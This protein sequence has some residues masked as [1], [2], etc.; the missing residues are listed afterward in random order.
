V[1]V[2]GAG[3]AGIIFC[4][5]LSRLRPDLKLVLLEYGEASPG[6]NSLDNSI[7]V[8]TP[9]HHH[10]PGES[11]NKGFGG[12]SRTWGGRCVSYDEIDFLDRTILGENCTWDPSIFED[13][14]RYFTIAADY[15]ECGPP[16][17]SFAECFP[18]GKGAI[19]DLFRSVEVTDDTLERWSRPTRF[20]EQHRKELEKRPNLTYLDPIEVHEITTSASGEVAIKGSR[21]DSTESVAIQAATVIIS[22]G[23][24]ETTRLL[25]KNPSLFGGKVPHSLGKFYQ[26]HVSGK[27]A[28]IQFSGDPKKTD[29]GFHLDGGVYVR[30]RFQFTTE[31]LVKH[32]LLNVALWLDN[33]LYGE[34]SH[35]NGTLS[36][37]YLMMK[38]PVLSRK[39]APPSIA[40]S[41]TKGG[42]SPVSAHL[43]NIV[44]NFPH[45]LLQP[46][47]LFAGRYLKAKKLPGVFLYN[48]Q[49]RYA[50]HFHSE[51]VPTEANYMRLGPDGNTLI[52]QY[53]YQ[54]EDVD[55]VIR[56]HD[57]L[58]KNLRSVNAGQLHYWHA[59]D[60][61]PSAILAWSKDGIHQVG[62]TRISKG[63][64]NGVVN[65]DLRLWSCDNV[66]VCSS[67]TF[68]TSGQANPTFLLAAFAAR[69]ADHISKL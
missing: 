24:Q 13:V 12:T 60:E 34:A 51:Q 66:Y 39:L 14:K 56:A 57:L 40:E 30:R 33:P 43:W 54:R 7:D 28:S 47:A 50:L 16:H 58:D 53:G 45:S 23:A 20:G 38:L 15:L 55:S 18:D 63:P 8:L 64:D 1:C 44:R 17:F 5:E 9:K 59:S 35:K 68:P 25:L 48:S 3:L 42:T 36:F 31:A 65:Y 26:G 32:N 11:T 10:P 19:S 41:V 2:V 61:L 27:I 62:T 29:F 6:E 49:N 4:L 21:R 52:I 22:S 37:I 69:L 67:S 46:A